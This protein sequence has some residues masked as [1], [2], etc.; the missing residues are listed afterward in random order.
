MTVDPA[1]SRQHMREE[2]A[3]VKE[4]AATNKWGIIPDFEQLTIKITMYACTGDLFIVEIRCDNYKEWPPYFEFIDPETGERATKH[5]YPK[6]TDSFFHDSGPCICA[7]FSR[8]AYKSVVATGPHGD[9]W[10]LGDW[11]T[12]T[13]NNVAWANYSKLGDMIGLIGNRLIQPGLYK[14]RMQ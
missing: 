8:K 9:D 7:P 14:G 1:I 11:Q 3:L 10:K 13:A 6:T 12:S 5:A 2:L 4:L